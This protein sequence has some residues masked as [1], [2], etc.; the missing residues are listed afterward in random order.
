MD[1]LFLLCRAVSVGLLFGFVAGPTTKFVILPRLF[2]QK[3][4]RKYSDSQMKKISKLWAAGSCALK[5]LT[6]LMLI[7]GFIWCVYFL[8]IGAADPA[9]TEY[10]NNMSEMIVAVL[11]VVSIGFA[12]FEFIK[13]K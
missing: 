5:Y 12:F 9:L 13:R 3:Y 4:P 6:G 10:A 11:T 7:L 8:V 2:P 1:F